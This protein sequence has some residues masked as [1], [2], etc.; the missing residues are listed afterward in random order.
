MAL[1]TPVGRMNAAS[2]PR[3]IAG[4][5]P[6]RLMTS[7]VSSAASA[8]RARPVRKFSPWR[9]SRASTVPM[10]TLSPT[11]IRPLSAAVASAAARK[12]SPQPSVVYAAI[13]GAQGGS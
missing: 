10:L 6:I 9:L 7:T 3:G 12:R 13:M 4:T 11:K 2:A 8:S 1:A 5:S